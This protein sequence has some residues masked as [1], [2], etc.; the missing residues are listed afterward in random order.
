[1]K[2]IGNVG[3]VVDGDEEARRDA[4]RMRGGKMMSRE[5]TAGAGDGAFA[6]KNLDE[7]LEFLD[8]NWR[9]FF[10][11][12]GAATPIRQLRAQ[13]CTGEVLSESWREGGREGGR[14]R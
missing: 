3:A 14:G 8:G 6:T 1:M 5:R 13:L 10:G 11:V 9:R 2:F 4:R 7:R 12:T